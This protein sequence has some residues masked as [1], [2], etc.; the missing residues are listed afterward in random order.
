MYYFLYTT[1]NNKIKTKRN[2]YKNKKSLVHFSPRE[3]HVLYNF[4]SF[5][6]Y[7]YYYYY[8]LLF[9]YIWR[10]PGNIFLYLA[11]YFMMCFVLW[12]KNYNIF[13]FS[14]HAVL[15]FHAKAF[16]CCLSFFLFFLILKFVFL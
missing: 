16:Q 14:L 12:T 2:T 5:F 11:T 13:I 10:C 6:S 8:Y 1:E 7:Y 9:C 4:P 3:I 15:F